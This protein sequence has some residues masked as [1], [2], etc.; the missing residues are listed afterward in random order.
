MPGL[1]NHQQDVVHAAL[2]HFAIG[3]IAHHQTRTP[4]QQHEKHR[5]AY[6][7]QRG[8]ACIFARQGQPALAKTVIF[9]K[10]FDYSS[11][12][13]DVLQRPFMPI[14]AAGRASIRCAQRLRRN[15][16]ACRTN[17]A[18]LRSSAVSGPMREAG[19]STKA[20]STMV[21]R[22]CSS[23]NETSASPTPSSVHRRGVKGR[24]STQRICFTAFWSRG[25]KARRVCCTRLPSWPN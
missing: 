23:K 25:V 12:L 21:G 7:Q 8:I 15:M 22:P 17:G 13:R 10:F 1:M 16:A 4:N 20:R 9:V 6:S 24:I 2:K 3:H 19:G 5:S 18:T 11:P 14:H